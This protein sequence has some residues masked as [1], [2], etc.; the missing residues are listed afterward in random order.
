MRDSSAAALEMELPAS[1]VL[2][3][4]ERFCLC[5]LEGPIVCGEG[6]C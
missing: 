2:E 3:E 5:F 1:G 4:A 6:V